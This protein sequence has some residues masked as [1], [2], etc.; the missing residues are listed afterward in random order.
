VPIA[1]K[2][3]AHYSIE[4]GEKLLYLFEGNDFVPLSLETGETVSQPIGG[5]PVPPLYHRGN[6]YACS[7]KGTLMVLNSETGNLRAETK[8]Q[9]KISAKPALA[10]SFIILGTAGGN[11]VVVNPGAYE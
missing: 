1:G 5:I 3:P 6:I 8:L 2:E 10:G 11:A 9:E 7:S 4:I